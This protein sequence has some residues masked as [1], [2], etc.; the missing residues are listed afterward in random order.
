MYDLVKT[1]SQAGTAM[2]DIIHTR[3]LDK[4]TR[5]II[6]DVPINAPERYIW[7]IHFL[8]DEG[9]AY[10]SCSEGIWFDSVAAAIAAGRTYY[11]MELARDEE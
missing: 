2:T 11:L 9:E 5:L 10:G 7:N 4:Y 1:P 3:E 8:D 6:R